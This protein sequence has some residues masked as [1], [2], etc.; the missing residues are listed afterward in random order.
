VIV[1]L[2][3]RFRADRPDETARAPGGAAAVAQDPWQ[4][5]QRLAA[6]GD[7]TQAAHALYAAI[8]Q[9]AAGRGIVR[10]HHAKTIGDY[11]RELRARASGAIVSGFRD[12]TR[13]YEVVVYGTGEC[14][15]QRFERLAQLAAAVR[16]NG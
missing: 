10:L 9:A 5:A 3:S 8:L 16:E 11:L 1:R 15:R 4:E 14:D 12:F 13:V 2:V 6:S 7:Y